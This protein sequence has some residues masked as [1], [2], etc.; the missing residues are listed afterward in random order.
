VG[1]GQNRRRAVERA[2][3]TDAPM[4]QE[5]TIGEEEAFSFNGVAGRRVLGPRRASNQQPNAA[6]DK[7][8]RHGR[9]GYHF[10]MSLH[11]ALIA[12]R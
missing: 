7:R 12:V 8:A 2:A 3:F 10:C 11:L 4:A 1:F 6:Q 9:G 5:T